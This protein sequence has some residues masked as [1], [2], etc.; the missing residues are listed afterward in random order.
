MCCYVVSLHVKTY[1]GKKNLNIRTIFTFFILRIMIYKN[2]GN[3]NKCSVVNL[4]ILSITELLHVSA[5]SP[6]SGN[7]HQNFIT[8]CSNECTFVVMSLVQFLVTIILCIKC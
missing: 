2:S 1:D 7:L 8:T 3:T 6:S 4:C 5:W